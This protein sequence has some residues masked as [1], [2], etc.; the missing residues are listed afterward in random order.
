MCWRRFLCK[1]DVETLN[2]F[3]CFNHRYDRIRSH[4]NIALVGK[5]TQLED[6]Y[7]S[8]I[9]SLRHA[10]FAVNKKLQLTVRAGLY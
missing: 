9:K 7:A 10:A 5:Y 2:C 6:S 3:D 1:L 8:V 4:C